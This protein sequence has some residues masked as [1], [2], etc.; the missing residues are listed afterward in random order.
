MAQPFATKEL[1]RD[2][3]AIAP[4]GSAVRVLLATGQGSLAHFELPA[5]RTSRA[6]SHRTVEEIWYFVG[7]RGEMWRRLEDQEEV[8][9]VKPG[10][11]LTIPLGTTFQFRA[12]GTKPLAA[13]AVTMPPWPGPGEAFEVPG[14]WPP[15]VG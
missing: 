7:G 1:P 11:C 5:G 4:D 12:S 10:V 3:G 8:V 2:P 9:A 6:V 13:V 15:T 14:R